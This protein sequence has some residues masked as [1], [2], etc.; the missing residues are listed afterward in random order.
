[1]L[2]IKFVRFIVGQKGISMDSGYIKTVVEWPLPRSFRDI[3]Q[4]LGFANFYCWFID[5]FSQVAA[6]LSNM[7]KGREKSKFKRKKFVLTKE[8][9]EVFEELKRLFTTILI[10]VHYNPA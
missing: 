7:F 6:S 9:R 4:F 10:L 5:V 2:E 3:Q 1:M 8:V